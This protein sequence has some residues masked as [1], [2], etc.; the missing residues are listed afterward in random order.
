MPDNEH[1]PVLN[2]LFRISFF[3]NSPKLPTLQFG[4]PVIQ[5]NY[6]NPNL[7][8]KKLAIVGEC[9]QA[10]LKRDE[11][12]MSEC[13]EQFKEEIAQETRA[14]YSK[15]KEE[16]EG[17]AVLMSQLHPSNIITAHTVYKK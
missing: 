4:P 11:E 1:L 13:Q 16:I 9:K 6:E 2:L 14:S 8:K 7:T 17:G 15:T 10:L 5:F 12:I 3:H